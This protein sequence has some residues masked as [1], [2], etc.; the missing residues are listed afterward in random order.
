MDSEQQRADTFEVFETL[1]REF[2]LPPQATVDYQFVPGRD[3]ADWD[4]FAE[5]ASSAGYQCAAYESDEHDDS[6]GPTLECSVFLTL[7]AEAVWKHEHALTQLAAEHGFVPDG[8]GLMLDADG[9]E[10]AEA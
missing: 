2:S 1:Q 8:W 10:V 4:G 9:N 5:S 6:V 7:G 3:D